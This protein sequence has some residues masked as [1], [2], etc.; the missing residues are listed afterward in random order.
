MSA[1]PH[2]LGLAKKCQSNFTKLEADLAKV[3][4]EVDSAAVAEGNA[5]SA[6]MMTIQL[7][8]TR[9]NLATL[10]EALAEASPAVADHVLQQTYA[11]DVLFK[12]KEAKKQQA[13]LQ[14]WAQKSMAFAK[15][16]HNVGTSSQGLKLQAFAQQLAA[17]ADVQRMVCANVGEMCQEIAE[18]R[19]ESEQS[20]W[21]CPD[22]QELVDANAELVV[23]M[24]SFEAQITAKVA[25]LKS[26]IQGATAIED[27]EE[28]EQ[29]AAVAAKEEDA[30][31]AKFGKLNA[32]ATQQ[33]TV[34][35]DVKVPN[36]QAAK[37]KL[38]Q[39]LKVTKELGKKRVAFGT[40]EAESKELA[41][42]DEGGRAKLAAEAEG[43]R[44][45]FTGLDAHLVASKP[46]L[47]DH[48]AR[49]TLIKKVM[50]EVKKHGQSIKA[51]NKWCRS[52]EGFCTNKHK[53]DSKKIMKYQKE[54]LKYI[55][56]HTEKLKEIA[57]KVQTQRIWG[58][59]RDRRVC[60]GGLGSRFRESV[61]EKELV[62]TGIVL[63]DPSH[64]SN[65]PPLP[66]RRWRLNTH[67]DQGPGQGDCW[68]QIQG[69][70]S[71][72]LGLGLPGSG[73]A[74]RGRSRCHR[75][76]LPARH[77]PQANEAG[78]SAEVVRGHGQ[79]GGAAR[80]REISYQDRQG[81]QEKGLQKGQ[82]R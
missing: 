62:A 35:D 42:I 48:F 56:H 50:A 54:G 77:Q 78:K 40:I 52:A 12:V 72:E 19:Y 13:G 79:A 81:A 26:D 73:Q 55:G 59:D 41:A 70:G 43:L 67:R 4:A 31:A 61:R 63:Q 15:K 36:L 29:S 46:I 9:A 2:S 32:W 6:A 82:E 10:G 51:L 27:A 53:G 21:S 71:G 60:G 14:K 1:Q 24:D 5:E 75:V 25:E 34:F 66:A 30:Y 33:A 76:P 47:D 23:Q 38:A 8:E 49:E 20:A 39:H 80:P 65:S 58:L 3:K 17:D 64:T 16:R 28:A 44:A 74:D 45:K 37:K 57:G 68:V 22:A 69:A 7:N 18:A 11:A